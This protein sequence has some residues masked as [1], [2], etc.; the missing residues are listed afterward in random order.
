[1]GPF[2]FAP[3][4]KVYTTSARDQL[5]GIP[6]GCQASFRRRRTNEIDAQY[7]RVC[8]RVEQP[9][10]EGFEGWEDKGVWPPE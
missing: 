7:E 4:P 10:D 6:E 9:L 2:L 1:M 8:A 3:T 5:E